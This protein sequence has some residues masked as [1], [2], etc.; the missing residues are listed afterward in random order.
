M[1]EQAH[2]ISCWRPARVVARWTNERP[3]WFAVLATGRSGGEVHTPFI[4]ALNTRK[5]TEIRV[6]PSTDS[7]ARHVEVS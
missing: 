6:V 5:G 3:G 1:S 4:R 2:N 7:L